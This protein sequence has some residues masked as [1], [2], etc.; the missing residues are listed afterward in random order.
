[1]TRRL[2]DLAAGLASLAVLAA[3]TVLPPLLLT[4]H[5]GWP[6]P[7]TIPTLAEVEHAIRTGIDPHVIVKA[8]ALIAWIAW[9]QITGTVLVETVAL[10]RR[11]SAPSLRVL[12]GL[13]PAI[14]RLVATAALIVTALLPT[15]TATIAAATGP[16]PATDAFAAYRA[17]VTI[18][19]PTDP[20]DT[21]P[22]A[23]TT[24]NGPGATVEVQRRD[25]LWAIAER[26]LGDGT[27]W[28]EVRDANLGRTMPDGTTI[29]PDTELIHPGWTLH[30]PS[31][32]PSKPPTQH[33]APTHA[34]TT[35]TTTAVDAEP[36]PVT[37]D[38]AETVLVQKGDHFWGI[39][40]QHLADAYDRPP[41]E[42]EIA[43]YWR[44]L[45]DA[46]RHLL[47]TGD[48]NVIYP[49]QQFTLPPVDGHTT[50]PN[51]ADTSDDEPPHVPVDAPTNTPD[52]PPEP[53]GTSDVPTADATEPADLPAPATPPS[54]TAA[55]PPPSPAP[56]PATTDTTEGTATDAEP[57]DDPGRLG[58]VAGAGALGIA[59]AGLLGVGVTRALRRRRLRAIH[60]DPNPN[61][62]PATPHPDLH[63]EVLLTSDAEHVD[64][65]ETALHELARGL[66]D[67]NTNARPRIVQHATD[68]LDVLLT[69]PTTPA[70][71]GWRSEA[72]GAI[73]THEPP[74]PG[75]DRN[76]ARPVA[77][78][79][80]T[81]G[82]P[83]DTGSQLLLDLE[84]DTLVTL[85]GDTDTALAVARSMTTEL[86]YSPLADTINL[87]LVGDLGAHAAARLERVT[88]ADDWSDVIDDLTAWTEQSHRAHTEHRWPN[89]FVARATHDHDALTPL[90]VIAQQPPDDPDQ[91][92]RLAALT[93]AAVAVVVVGELAAATVIDC[94]PH[95][96]VIRDLGL[97]C[98]PQRL[99][100]ETVEQIADLLEPVG[101]TTSPPAANGDTPTPTH[102]M[103]TPPASDD[104]PADQHPSRDPSADIIVRLLGDITIDG[105]PRSLTP[106]QTAVTTYI[107][108]NGPVSGDRIEDA[109]W[110][111]PTSGS[112]RKRL[113][114]IL[115]E[116][117]KA[118][119][120]RHLPA[121]IDGRYTTA[122]TVTT[123]LE[124][125]DRRVVAA[126]TQ[127]PTEAIVTLRAAL[128]LVRGP[129]F[130]YRAADRWSYTWIDL[131]NWVS[132][133]EP[134]IAAVA[135]HLTELCLDH[136]D[137]TGA[138][139]AATHA[140]GIVPT[141]IGL[142]E[143]LMRA[144]AAN[145]DPTSI[146]AVYRAHANALE[147]LDLD[148]VADTTR[149]LYDQ[150]RRARATE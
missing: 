15:A 53:H 114:N 72:N 21:A 79:L 127:P 56:S 58:L 52:A 85:T 118:L 139:H 149:D 42:D 36:E 93:P 1:M 106:K 24:A 136:H 87:V 109:I 32:T 128:D 108:L 51:T 23:E 117:R 82:R 43:T 122:I 31:G 64:T 49:G 3:L 98:E 144:H 66:A 29:G 78:L 19:L 134:K 34:T 13:Q 76:T 125:F 121:A 61:H 131:E 69:E 146:D 90:V 35:T 105:A 119:G 75:D 28:P 11:R 150:L 141:H 84:A 46:N 115:S 148:D 44:E 89:S 83:D 132:R 62:I 30:L 88:V 54:A 12:P 27:R 130:T 101:T 25:S 17:P 6:L 48:P 94:Q 143:A 107:A 37:P 65:L 68:H 96:L 70:V 103:T 50:P 97:I 135:Q 18:T 60:L 9:A 138:I 16:S 26:T 2:T 57:T 100:I 74:I 142:T 147:Q 5:V 45:I 104:E 33:G 22:P 86:A 145:N 8:L 73:W 80:V 95:Q 102:S 67:N 4:R 137:P 71:P 140:L 59:G 124:L 38:E 126:S 120:S 92:S 112:R 47:P 129:V 63:R 14:G 39:A 55:P 41:T 40:L 116:C 133:W 7:T 81:L 20:T 10:L 91:L 99:T 111:A 113:A 77:P 123:D 110:A